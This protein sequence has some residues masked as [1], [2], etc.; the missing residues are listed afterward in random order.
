[1]KF[2]AKKHRLLIIVFLVASTLPVHSASVKFHNINQQVGISMRETASV[3]KDDNGFIWTS[4]KTGVLRIAGNDHRIYQLPFRKMNVIDVRLV[5]KNSVLIA[6]SHNGQV[7]RYNPVYDRFDFLFDLDDM[8]NANTYLD[9]ISF[10]IDQAGYFWISTSMGFYQYRQGNLIKV[11][12]NVS[13]SLCTFD[14]NHLLFTCMDGISLINVHTMERKT[15]HVYD[16]SFDFMVY[17]LFYDSTANGLWIGTY[18]DGLFYYDFKT[19]K[20]SERLAPVFPK[21]PVRAIEIA[22]DSTV[23][24]GIDGQGIREINKKGDRIINTYK[25]NPEDKNSIRGN[26]IY[27]ILN[28]TENQRVWVCTYSGGLSYFEQNPSS[29]IHL[30]H[31]I[32]NSNSLAND[33]VNQIIEDSRGNIWFA[34]DNGISCWNVHSGKWQTFFRNKL[35]HAQVFLSLCEDDRNRIWAGTYSSGVYVLDANTGHVLAHHSKNEQ[36]SSFDNNFT[37]DIIKDGKGNLWIGGIMEKIFRYDSGKNTFEA[38]PSLPIYNFKD[39]SENELLAS[40]VTGLYRIEKHLKKDTLL[41]RGYLLT[42]FLCIDSVVWMCTQG[43][44]LVRFDMKSKDV[45]EFTTELGLPSNFVNSIQFANGYLWLGTE[46]GLCKF[47]TA[48]YS[49]INY[50]NALP[51][52]SFNRNAKCRLRNGQLAWGTSNGVIIF[53]PALL[54]QAQ[55][56]GRIFVQD[57]LVSG[58]SIRDDDAF[59]LRTSLDSLQ[60]ITLKYNQNNLAMELLPLDGASDLKFSWVIEGFD[61]WSSHPSDDRKLTYTNIPTGKYVL[62]ISMYDHSMSQLIAERRFT[63]RVTPPFWETGWFRLLMFMIVAGM[64]YFSLWFY[65]NMLKRK[66]S[67]D[68]ISFFAN[69]AHEIRTTVSLIKAPIEELSGKNFTETDKYC[70]DLATEQARRLSSTVTHLLD[71][72]KA[73]IGKGQLLLTMVNVVDLIR[74]RLLMFESFAKSKNIELSFNAEPASYTSAIDEQKIEKAIDNLISNAVKYSHP[75]SKVQLMF[76]GN[77]KHWTLEVKD[78]GIGISRKAQR[79]MFRKFY[80][81]EN[82]INSSNVGSGIGL[83]LAKN[84]VALHG[85]TIRCVSRENAGSSFKI[86]IPFKKVEIAD[87]KK[88]IEFLSPQI[89]MENTDDLQENSSKK[90]HLLIVED[91]EDLR[92]FMTNALGDEF[93][94]LTANDGEI[95]WKIIRKRMPD[96][97]ISDIMMPNMNGFELCRLIKSTFETS[98]IPV[99]LLTALAGKAEQ[100]HGLGL[101]ADNYLTK[102]F[103]MAL[104]TQSVRSI[105]Q[106]RKAV[107]N[108]AFKLSEKNKDEIIFTNKLNDTFMKKAIEVVWANME[109]PEFDRDKFASAMNS[110]VSL[111]YKKIKALTGQSPLDFIKTMRL[112]HAMELLQTQNHTVTEVSDLCGFSSISYFG[113]T[114]K[115]HFGKLPS[116]IMEHG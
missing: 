15:V 72:Q 19:D 74:Y 4:S 69:M 12:D 29:I 2:I 92:N 73:D 60:E 113:K 22:S 10:L 5:C 48:D 89:D 26:G 53:D 105:I 102:P 110:S 49:V 87:L 37:Y 78:Y 108:K 104:V 93:D 40:G 50:S 41:L 47:S 79:K 31:E 46:A 17:S 62:K 88:R 91:H 16:H 115:K 86:I 3:C 7:F 103:D 100:L 36:N 6:Y 42:D 54:L 67:E 65:I 20:L 97:V 84:Y 1:M 64:I 28:D 71:F 75:D 51:Y 34:T 44:G 25:E 116:E 94:V 8:L 83:L 98:H 55:P 21:Q 101:G 58:R 32:N 70:L 57:I 24:I 35:E 45:R 90:M 77:E 52:V 61:A 11:T 13:I 114:F 107:K 18:S 96:M 85:G 80:R 59:D 23:F 66:H 56:Q 33:N 63:V 111:L 81:S 112:N 82:A 95:A 38:G 30:V 43:N 14:D 109:N 106:N 39:F 99:V 27:D 68:K 76:T 9:I